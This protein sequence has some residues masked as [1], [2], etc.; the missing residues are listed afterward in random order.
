MWIVPKALARASRFN[1]TALS[2]TVAILMTAGISCWGQYTQ[3]LFA[4]DLYFCNS[5]DYE[6]ASQAGV[7]MYLLYYPGWYYVGAGPAQTLTL[8]KSSGS[9]YADRLLFETAF[10]NVGTNFSQPGSWYV[11]VVGYG[12][13]NRE[14]IC[15]DIEYAPFTNVISDS[16]YGWQ[17]FADYNLQYQ[18]HWS[19]DVYTGQGYGTFNGGLFATN[20]PACSNRQSNFSFTVGSNSFSRWDT[21]NRDGTRF[22]HRRDSYGP[23]FIEHRFAYVMPEVG[24]YVMVDG[25]PVPGG[26]WSKFDSTNLAAVSSNM[27]NLASFF[28]SSDTNTIISNANASVT[29]QTNQ[30]TAF[31]NMMVAFV[32]NI[33]NR[34]VRYFSNQLPAMATGLVLRLSNSV[35]MIRSNDIAVGQKRMFYFFG[36]TGIM[37][38][39]G[40]E[41][42]LTEGSKAAEFV[43]VVRLVLRIA[44]WAMTSLAVVSLIRYGIGA[45]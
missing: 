16:T 28:S 45:T 19:N 15:R 8:Y 35:W 29:D 9:Q 5:E 22:W 30:D 18:G 7:S 11:Q 38:E 37:A 32:T 13:T 12:N 26:V 20:F 10:A 23:L 3:V 27:Y 21:L 39:A 25:A 44:T 2:A 24:D 43:L 41:M 42:D 17:G 36:D 34:V 14:I 1:R 33:T 4:V 31:T 6:R 40:Y